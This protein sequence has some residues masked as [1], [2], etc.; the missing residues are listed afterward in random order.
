MFQ[1]DISASGAKKAPTANGKLGAAAAEDSD[2]DDDSEEDDSEEGMSTFCL[3]TCRSKPYINNVHREDLIK[4][5][6]VG[7]VWIGRPWKNFF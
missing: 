1:E 4:S 6:F 2:D 7:L 3:V 5:Y